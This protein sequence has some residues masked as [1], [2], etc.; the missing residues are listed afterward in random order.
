MVRML[1]EPLVMPLVALPLASA[2]AAPV[3]ARMAIPELALTP[4]M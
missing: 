3:G 4:P 1:N 2:V